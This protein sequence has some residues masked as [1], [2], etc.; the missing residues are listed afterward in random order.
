MTPSSIAMKATL[1]LIMAIDWDA[2]FT[3]TGMPIYTT[4]FKN[5]LS[6]EVEALAERWIALSSSK[7]DFST[8]P[9][10]CSKI[11]LMQWSVLQKNI[12]LE[13]FLNHIKYTLSTTP[14]TAEEVFPVAFLELLDNTYELSASK[15][16]EVMLRWHQICIVCEAQ[17]I[18][19]R[20]VEFIS[21]QGRMKY[22]RPLYRLLRGSTM[23]KQI[24]IDTFEKKKDS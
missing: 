8:P 6:I 4:S 11:D 7:E 12:F 24:A 21:S 9:T 3:K 22:V 13:V 23:G 2:I 14:L 10:G 19:P 18:L 5:S 17:W 20:V 15:N 16:C 1:D